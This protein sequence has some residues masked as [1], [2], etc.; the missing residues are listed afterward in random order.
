[1]RQYTPIERQILIEVEA[2]LDRIEYETR[3]ELDMD[4]KAIMD[5]MSRVDDL[6]SELY[7]LKTENE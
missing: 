4:E 1:M 3:Q 7:E 5:L 2:R 6:E